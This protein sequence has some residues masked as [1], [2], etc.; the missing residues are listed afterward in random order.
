MAIP[1][2]NSGGVI[3]RCLES[4]RRQTYPHLEVLVVDGCSWDGTPAVAAAYGA[5]VVPCAGGLLAARYQGVLRCHGQ[6]VL[7]LDSDQVLEPTAVERAVAMMEQ[8]YDMLVLEEMSFRPRTWLQRLFAAHRRLIHLYLDEEALDPYRGTVLPRFFRRELL[9]RALQGVPEGLLE[10]VVHHDHAIIYLECWRLSRRVGFLPRAVYHQEPSSLWEVVRRNFR[11]GRSLAVFAADGP[12]A[13]LARRRDGYVWPR[14]L[15]PRDVPLA[16][17]SALLLT[18]LKLAQ[19][20][21]LLWERA[22]R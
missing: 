9:L 16:V 10:R 17:Q 15:R 4:V 7:M 1:T 2:R 11:Y 18:L 20:A 21:G 6:F 19:G 14:R 22:T 5:T 8:G 13:D 3:G 12:Y